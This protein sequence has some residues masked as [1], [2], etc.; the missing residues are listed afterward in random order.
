MFIGMFSGLK[1]IVGSKINEEDAQAV[2]VV[3]P[4]LLVTPR[5]EHSVKK[6]KIENGNLSHKKR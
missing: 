6:R 2:T 5:I 1:K 3:M 4:D